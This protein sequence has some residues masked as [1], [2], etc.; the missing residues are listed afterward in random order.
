MAALTNIYRSTICIL[1]T[2]N[3]QILIGLQAKVCLHFINQARG[4][5]W[6]NIGPRSY[7][8]T[9]LTALGLYRKDQGPKFSQYDPER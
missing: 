6:E 4:P 8:S 2:N 5:S 7:Q 3:S 1:K 9:D